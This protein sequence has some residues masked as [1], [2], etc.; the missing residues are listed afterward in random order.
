MQFFFKQDLHQFMHPIRLFKCGIDQGCNIIQTGRMLPAAGLIAPDKPAEYAIVTNLV[1]FFIHRCNGQGSGRHV[2][3][4]QVDVLIMLDQIFRD[5]GGLPV[6]FTFVGQD[7]FR[8][9]NGM[10]NDP[11]FRIIIDYQGNVLPGFRIEQRR[12]RIHHP[13]LVHLLEILDL[14]IKPGFLEGLEVRCPTHVFI[15]MI[16]LPLMNGNRQ[17][18]RFFTVESGE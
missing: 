5:P 13:E 7:S 16:S 3:T 15:Q 14:S 17:A 8:S 10:M 6:S 18:I 11:L 1:I 4:D 2:L 9:F 12:I